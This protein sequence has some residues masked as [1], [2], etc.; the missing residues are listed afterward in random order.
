MLY[1][2]NI[3]VSVYIYIYIY[4]YINIYIHIYIYI[5][6]PHMYIVYLIVLRRS[7]NEQQY[8]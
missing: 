4:V 2:Y 6:I 1:I 5:Y 8:N 3:Y 7:L